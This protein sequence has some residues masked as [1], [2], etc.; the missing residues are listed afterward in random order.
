MPAPLVADVLEELHE[1]ER[2]FRVGR[3][4][5]Q[6]LVEAPGD[7]VVEIDVEQ[8]AHRPRLRHVV[9]EV[10]AGHVLVRD[11]GVHPDHLGVLER[12]DEGQ[13][14][15]DRGQIDVGPR[16]VRLGL[17]REPQV[18]ALITHVA[19]QEVEGVGVP[20]EGGQRILRRIGLHALSPAPE[21]VGGGAELHAEIDGAHRLLERERAHTRVVRREGPVAE[22]RVAEQVR[23]GHRHDE[24][25]RIQRL[26]EVGHDLIALVRARVDRHEVVVVQVHSPCADLGQELDELD[27]REHLARGI[28]EGV[29]AGVTDRPQ[30]EREPVLLCGF[31][32]HGDIALLRARR[33]RRRRAP[34]DC[35]SRVR[36]RARRRGARSR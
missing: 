25:G 20:P 32:R 14:R 12:L 16:L 31:V 1:E 2:R 33:F 17:E 11:L 23:G 3:A 21:D 18:V 9:R 15:A 5:P 19:A 22:H 7:L 30:P 6:V 35:A 36:R 10:Q 26:A 24:A 29:E 13:H 28:P 34:S 8:L 27:G 4:E